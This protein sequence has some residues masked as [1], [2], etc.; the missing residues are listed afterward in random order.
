[1]INVVRKAVTIV[2]TARTF[3]AFFVMV[4]FT[5]TVSQ[6]GGSVADIDGITGFSGGH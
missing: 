2:R 4:T 5:I 1:M 3:K 6:W